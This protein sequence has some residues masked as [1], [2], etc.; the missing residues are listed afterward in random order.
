MPKK[1]STAAK[2]TRAVALRYEPRLPAPFMAA[3][4]SGRSA[5]RLLA[6]AREAGVGILRDEAL[7]DA[8]YPL[9]LGDFVPEEYYEIVARAFV[10]VKSIE[11]A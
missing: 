3:K 8:I 4:A 11:E 1:G 5:E 9:D 2:R 6:I 10:F 7:L